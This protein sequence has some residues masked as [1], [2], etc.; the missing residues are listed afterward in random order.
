MR[1]RR[2]LTA[3]GGRL[4]RRSWRLLVAAALIA[5]LGGA[6]AAVAGPVTVALYRFQSAG[7]ASAFYKVRGNRCAK[8]WWKQRTLG[9]YV[10][11]GTNACGFRSSVVAASGDPGPDQE[12]SAAVALSGRTPRNLRRRI[13]LAVAVRQSNSAGYELRVFPV[14]QVW[15]LWR[16]PRGA[17]GPAR[18][19]AG[20]GNFIRRGVG[21]RNYLTIRAFDYG[22]SAPYL[23]ARINRERV[24]LTRDRRG[25]QPN[26]RRTVVSV[27]AFK[28]AATGALGTFDNVAIRVPN[29]F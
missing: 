27:G 5:V 25:A 11:K 24:L 26:G 29:P 28:G 15:Q 22:S 23:L 21:R 8:R 17:A 14:A 10:A 9:I 13:Y 18:I 3:A 6:A 4:P 2:K 7:D 1:I 12:M 16:D 20:K 19:A